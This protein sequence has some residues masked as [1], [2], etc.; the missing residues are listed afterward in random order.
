MPGE[1]KAGDLAR[2]LNTWP[3]LRPNDPVDG[4]VLIV[5][6][7]HRLP[8]PDRKEQVYTRPEFV[9]TLTFPVLSSWQL[10]RW[11]AEDDHASIV[12]ALFPGSH[13][14]TNTRSPAASPK[15]QRRRLWSRSRSS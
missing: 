12:A 7:Q 10:F 5:N 1:D 9:A 2:H 11:W 3:Q 4:G 6:H 13:A 8:P 15:T 14:P